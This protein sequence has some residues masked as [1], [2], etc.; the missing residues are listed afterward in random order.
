MAGKLGLRLMNVLSNERC[1]MAGGSRDVRTGFF[2]Y[3]MLREREQAVLYILLHCAS[4]ACPRPEGII[5][6][7]TENCGD[8]FEQ[9][10][11]R[12]Y[13]VRLGWKLGVGRSELRSQE[14]NACFVYGPTSE[15]C[16]EE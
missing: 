1:W 7:S 13:R 3:M 8:V 5:M 2:V 6:P 12:C 9:R 11:C 4:H 15:L 14:P 10:G 16:F